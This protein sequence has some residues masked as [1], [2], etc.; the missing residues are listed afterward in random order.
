MKAHAERRVLIKPHAL[1][2]PIYQVKC[3]VQT[4]KKIKRICIICF[5][6]LFRAEV[7]S[8]PERVVVVNRERFAAECTIRCVLDCTVAF[9]LYTIELLECRSCSS[10]IVTMLLAYRRSQRLDYF[11]PVIQNVDNGASEHDLFRR[12][13]CKRIIPGTNCKRRLHFCVYIND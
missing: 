7:A 1:V 11:R 8:W 9:S 4:C 2:F 12:L 3:C 5:S 6:I 10:T 13:E